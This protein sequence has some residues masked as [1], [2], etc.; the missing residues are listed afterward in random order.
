MRQYNVVSLMEYVYTRFYELRFYDFKNN[1]VHNLNEK[2]KVYENNGISI[3]MYL[4]YIVGVRDNEIVFIFWVYRERVRSFTVDYVSDSTL[5]F[6]FIHDDWLSVYNESNSI[7]VNLNDFST[8]LKCLEDAS[9]DYRK[10]RSIRLNTEV[11]R[12]FK[13]VVYDFANC[14]ALVI[15]V[16]SQNSII[17]WKNSFWYRKNML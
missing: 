1:I 7:D 2:T 17:F 5:R 4:N 15:Y 13:W 12:L 3:F 10:Q 16:F 8:S 14:R 9:A 11:I 6:N